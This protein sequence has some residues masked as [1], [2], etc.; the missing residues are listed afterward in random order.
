MY[1]QKEASDSAFADGETPSVAIAPNATVDNTVRNLIV[2]T[3]QN[4]RI[5]TMSIHKQE[6]ILSANVRMKKYLVLGP[7]DV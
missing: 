7:C 6:L 4:R 3:L 1:P 5:C 2:K